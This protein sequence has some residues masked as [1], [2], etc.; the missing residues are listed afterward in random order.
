MIA[1]TTTTES[2]ERAA[3]SLT[4]ESYA[5]TKS[6]VRRLDEKR[7]FAE[8]LRARNPEALERFYDLYFDRILQLR[9]TSRSKRTHC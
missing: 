8:R 9:P 1:A 2:A 5:Q 3:P 7:E 6:P 4:V